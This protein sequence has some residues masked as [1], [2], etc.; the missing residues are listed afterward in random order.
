MTLADD[1]QALERFDSLD[2]AT[3]E[4][5]ATWPVDDEALRAARRS[6]GPGWPPC[7][8]PTSATTA[9]ASGCSP[10]RA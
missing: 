7:G 9:A 2:P 3:G 4:V 8:G 1:R 6:T 10:G 5:L